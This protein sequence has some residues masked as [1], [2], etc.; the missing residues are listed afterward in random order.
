VQPESETTFRE[1]KLN[2]DDLIPLRASLDGLL[3]QGKPIVL[4]IDGWAT[5]GKTSL[6][7]TLTKDY[8]SR[9][10]HTDDFFLP[11]ELRTDE[12]LS[13]PGGNLHYERFVAAVLPGLRQKKGFSYQAFDCGFMQL[14]AWRSLAP[15]QLTIVEGSYALHPIFGAY[16]DISIFMT[17][18]PKL[19]LARIK[20]RN[21]NR[22]EQFRKHWIPIEEAYFQAF[23]IEKTADF[24]IQT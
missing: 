7:E 17:C 15:A 21:P 14:G 18:P 1:N 16:Y 13:K 9:V 8:Q 20:S 3:S 6:L 11:Q 12:R 22:L 10:V 4:A 2:L 24:T 23:S 5:S 19:Q